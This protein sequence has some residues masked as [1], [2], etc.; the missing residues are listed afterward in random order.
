MKQ[1]PNTVKK[2]LEILIEDTNKRFSGNL[3][4]IVKQCKNGIVV[5]Y[6]SCDVYEHLDEMQ[7]IFVQDGIFEEA[8][9][10]EF[11][12]GYIQM[13]ENDDEEPEYSLQELCYDYHEWIRDCG[14]IFFRFKD[15][16]KITWEETLK[17]CTEINYRY[18]TAII[19]NGEYHS[20]KYLDENVIYF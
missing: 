17:I 1:N 14:N 12:Q 9:I 3:A 7:E 6:D 19:V 8:M 5:M 10:E 4:E 15:N 18:P 2:A 16:R 13:I 11:F 20:T